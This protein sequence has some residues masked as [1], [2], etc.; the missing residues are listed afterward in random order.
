MSFKSVLQTKRIP[1]GD[2]RRTE[3]TADLT[4]FDKKLDTM[5]TVPKGTRTD[6]ASVPRIFWSI[7]P[8]RGKYLE[9]AVLHDYLYQSPPF[10]DGATGRK[11]ADAIFRRAMKSQ[12]V[13]KFKR[14]LMYRAVRA[15]GGFI[16]RRR[17][18]KD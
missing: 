2:W 9:S 18:N 17:H 14:N 13:G 1:G 6:G 10:G 16:W 4:Y 7:L 11:M 5:F 12:G 15:G 8:P 3:L